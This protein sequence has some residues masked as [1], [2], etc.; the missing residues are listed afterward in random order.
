MRLDCTLSPKMLAGRNL[1]TF[2]S[3]GNVAVVGPVS[4]AA[5]SYHS[6]E[7]EPSMTTVQLSGLCGL[8]RRVFRGGPADQKR[9]QDAAI[10]SVLQ[11]PS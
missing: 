11:H 3:Q 9:E 6:A 2:A 7:M 1:Q 5:T 10:V 4:T 8:T